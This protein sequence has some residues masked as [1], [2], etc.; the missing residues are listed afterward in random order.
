MSKRL[1]WIKGDVSG[2]EDASVVE[3]ARGSG[4]ACLY[5]VYRGGTERWLV[6]LANYY[7]DGAALTRGWALTREEVK[8]IAERW[9]ELLS[10][11]D[12]QQPPVP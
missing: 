5:R 12:T 6:T 11:W 1:E 7:S 4:E 2:H 9:D 8:E 10:W 3:S